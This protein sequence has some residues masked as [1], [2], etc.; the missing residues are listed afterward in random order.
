MNK[1]LL[2]SIGL[3]ES[4]VV[5]YEAVLKAGG[6]DPA[7]LGKAAGVKRT[8]A[9]SVARGLVE[10][11]LLV[12]DST[13]RPRIF[14]PAGP[15]EVFALID[16]EKQRAAERESTLTKLAGELSK[17][18]ET[19]SYPVPTVRF[20]EEGKI[21]EFLKQQSPEWDAN[22]LAIDELTWWGSQDHTFVEHFGDWV[23]WYWKQSPE[24][25]DLQLL[26]NHADAEVEFAE[27]ADPRRKIKFWGEAANFLST[28]WAIGDYLV[29]INTRTKP[30]YL[31]EI[32]DNLMAHDQRE[33]FKNLWPLV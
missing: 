9:Y 3:N 26:S 23:T 19:T 25:I 15:K 29:M 21:R 24:K 1:E 12:E 28:T 2:G 20:V 7:A 32:H 4:E 6:I 18:S 31:V 30:F 14:T 16:A 10:K 33:V 17:L 8:T 11:G 22:M 13:K 27:Q 5:V